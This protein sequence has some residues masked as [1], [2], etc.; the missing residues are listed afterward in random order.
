MVC[1]EL[2]SNPPGLIVMESPSPNESKQKPPVAYWCGLLGSGGWSIGWPVLY[3]FVEPA[4]P[5]KTGTFYLLSHAAATVWFFSLIAFVVFMGLL[6]EYSPTVRCLSEV[7]YWTLEI[8]SCF[9]PPW[10]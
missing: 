10:L 8:L 6:A 5:T 3:A 4:V 1:R 2:R 9:M 7:V